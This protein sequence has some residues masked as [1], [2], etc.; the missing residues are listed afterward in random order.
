MTDYADVAADAFRWV[1]AQAVEAPGGLAWTE[2]GV[3]IDD[4]YVGTAGVLLA[5]AEATGSGVDCA[6][7]A[8]QGAW[9]AASR[10]G[11]SRTP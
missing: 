3:L 11:P 2:N 6:S 1:A 4:L 9:P 5:A 10:G 8:S 7:L